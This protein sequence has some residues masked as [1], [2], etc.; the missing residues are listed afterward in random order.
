MFTPPHTHTPA[1]S[2]TSI[3]PY[4]V[5][6]VL[7]RVGQDKLRKE[8]RVAF[9]TLSKACGGDAGTKNPTACGDWEA[10]F[11]GQVNAYPHISLY[12]LG[13]RSEKMRRTI[14]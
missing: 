1:L 12:T 14:C 8:V 2:L 5:G 4:G 10:V 9:T 13:P 3:R 6:Q 7:S 11:M